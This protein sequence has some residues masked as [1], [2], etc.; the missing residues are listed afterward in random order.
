MAN[1]LSVTVKGTVWGIFMVFRFVDGKPKMTGRAGEVRPL[2]IG[3]NLYS[4]SYVDIKLLFSTLNI[5]NRRLRQCTTTQKKQRCFNVSNVGFSNGVFK[6]F[7][8]VSQPA[9]PS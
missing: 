8:L 7:R 5:K 1:S 4:M 3:K 2:I 9:D 6:C